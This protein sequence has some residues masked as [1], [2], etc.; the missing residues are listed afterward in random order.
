MLPL[1]RKG[2]GKK[3]GKNNALILRLNHL[4]AVYFEQKLIAKDKQPLGPAD[5]LFN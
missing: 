1:G 5:F 2:A 3:T 4:E